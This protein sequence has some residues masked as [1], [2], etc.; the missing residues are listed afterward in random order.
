[1]PEM[2]E[3]VAALQDLEGVHILK[4]QRQAAAGSVSFK[5]PFHQL[6]NVTTLPHVPSALETHDRM[7]IELSWLL[8]KALKQMHE[9]LP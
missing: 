5:R 1:M 8:M 3:A 6:N 7:H 4:Y 2:E 9:M